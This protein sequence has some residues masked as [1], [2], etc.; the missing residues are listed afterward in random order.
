MYD[1]PN[2]CLTYTPANTWCSQHLSKMYAY[3]PQKMHMHSCMC[4][5][6]T[7]Q[8]L[9]YHESYCERILSLARAS[10]RLSFAVRTPACS[11]RSES[12]AWRCS[13]KKSVQIHASSWRG[14]RCGVAQASF[15]HPHW[16]GP[17]PVLFLW[18]TFA[19]GR[20]PHPPKNSIFARAMVFAGSL[21]WG[22][23]DSRDTNNLVPSCP[24]LRSFHADLLDPF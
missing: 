10:Y 1:F 24:I 17:H 15:N 5:Y 6:V 14:R 13:L 9:L 19:L 20:G 8:Q 12:V 3:L 2:T 4:A 16:C 7:V 11:T 22:K 21:L 23:D 18:F